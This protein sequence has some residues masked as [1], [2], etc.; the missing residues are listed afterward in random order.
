MEAVTTTPEP[1]PEHAS[2]RVCGSTSQAPAIG[3]FTGSSEYT[4]A[5]LNAGG[6]FPGLVGPFGKP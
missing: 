2:P 3:F 4:A 6:N 5:T 1:Y